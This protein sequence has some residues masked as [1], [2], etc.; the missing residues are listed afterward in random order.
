MQLWFRPARGP[1]VWLMW[2]MW[3][4]RP[5]SPW[6]WPYQYKQKTNTETSL[7]L[8]FWTGLCAPFSLGSMGVCECW[9]LMKWVF[10]K[11]GSNAAEKVSCLC[12]LCCFFLIQCTYWRGGVEVHAIQPDN[13]PFRVPKGSFMLYAAYGDVRAYPLFIS[14][15]Y[16]YVFC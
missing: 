15:V 5:A 13:E 6:H 2:P 12:A 7:S 4:F 8:N 11:M 9:S 10:L 3:D 16:S 1:G 14:C